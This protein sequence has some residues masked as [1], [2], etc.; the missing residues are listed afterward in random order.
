M[1]AERI[2]VSESVMG[3][4]SEKLSQF[5]SKFQIHGGASTDNATRVKALVEDSISKGG[6]FLFDEKMDRDGSRL[7]PRIVTNVNRDMDIWHTETFGPVAVLA[8]FN[9]VDEAVDLANDSAYGLSASIFSANIPLAMS[10]AKRLDSGAVHINSMTVHDEAHLP[11][12]GV[13]GSGWGRFGVPWG[14]IGC[15]ACMLLL[16]ADNHLVSRLFR[17]YPAQ[18]HY[19]NRRASRI[20]ISYGCQF[21][22]TTKGTCVVGL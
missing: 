10:I 22:S 9:T 4:F 2:I 21:I 8:S 11:H 1:S 19:C 3:P 6:S 20:V 18:D 16:Y 13:K 5:A 15:S 14:E 12:G 7:S 17:V